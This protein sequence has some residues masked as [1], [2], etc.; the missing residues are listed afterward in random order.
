[1]VGA[2]AAAD[3]SAVCEAAIA[4]FTIAAPSVDE[5][6]APRLQHA[7]RVLDRF[8]VIDRIRVDSPGG[9]GIPI[10][11][12]QA[13]SGLLLLRNSISRVTAGGSI[14][15][16]VFGPDSGSGEVQLRNVTVDVPTAT[17][18]GLVAQG[19]QNY[20]TSCG[21]LTVDVKNS[22]LRGGP[23]ERDVRARR[24]RRDHSTPP[25]RRS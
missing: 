14:G 1:M 20:G 18:R 22:Y 6:P 23:P 10:A 11:L 16:N 4:S 19:G 3:V 17:G 25:A 15:I 24:H 12:S 5:G 2:T 21:N 9:S 7:P 8:A 13:G